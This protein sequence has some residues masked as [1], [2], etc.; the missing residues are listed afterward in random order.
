MYQNISHDFKTPITVMKS[1]IEA[2]EDGIQTKEETLNII[3]EQLKKLE[4][5]VHSLLYLNKLN[6]LKMEKDNL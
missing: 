6:Y 2:A 3:K 4:L 5:K 1:Y